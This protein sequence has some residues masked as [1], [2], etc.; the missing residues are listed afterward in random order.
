MNTTT[1]KRIAYGAA[2]TAL[3]MPAMAFAQNTDRFGVNYGSNAGLGTRD[4]RDTVTAI[5]NVALGVLGIVALLIILWGGLTWM[6]AGGNEE[7]TSQARKIIASG[8][9]GLI[10][11]FVAYAL[12]TFIFG[13]LENAT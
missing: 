11:I 3:T 8:V 7:K 9:V 4:V 1:V 5:I 13:V 6:T 12:T 2:A 10:V